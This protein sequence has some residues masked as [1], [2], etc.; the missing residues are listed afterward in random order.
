MKNFTNHQ[1]KLLMVIGVL[2][3]AQACKDDDSGE[4][5]PEPQESTGV[6]EFWSSN[7]GQ[8]PPEA[9]K[10]SN[11][12]SRI[13]KPT[14]LDFNPTR[15]GELWIVNEEVENTGGS[16]VTIPDIDADQLAFTRLQDQNAWHFMSLPT[17]I[18]FSETGDWATSAG[19]LDANHNGGT[20]TGPTLW[21]GDLSVYAQP[22]GGN[23]SHL[24][25]LHGSPYSMGIASEK[26]NVFWVF[27]GY[28]SELVRY[29]FWDD[30][31]P[32]NDYHA[33]GI[34]RRFSNVELTRN[35]TVPSHLAFTKN[36]NFLLV[37]D[38][39]KNRVLKV[40]MAS[41]KAERPLQN[42]NETL[43]E[44]SEWSASFSVLT[45]DA[46]FEFCGIAVNDGRVFLSDY[47]TGTILC[48]DAETGDEISR[49]DTG[50]EGITGLAIYD[51]RLFFVSYSNHAVYEL[52]PRS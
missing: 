19:V 36:N 13:F 10:L 44:H 35:E 15:K 29:D 28:H 50:V 49:V 8:I 9:V 1:F 22:S 30:H 16:T 31:G 34:V 14:D 32:G 18:A 11:A 52:E 48:L 5:T 3:F 42:L 33:D 41:L 20:F 17:G 6:P 12:S 21:S 38:G 39:G 27:D 25:M 37:V 26:K 47:K 40:D 7:D 45:Q 46:E 24:D 51:D 23:G 43:A 4:P 2:L